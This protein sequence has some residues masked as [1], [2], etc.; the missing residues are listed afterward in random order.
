M[1]EMNLRTSI[2]SSDL[3]LEFE[4]TAAESAR[5][6]SALLSAEQKSVELQ[7]QLHDRDSEVLQVRQIHPE[8]AERFAELESSVTAIM[9]SS[10]QR[11]EQDFE[12]PAILE[13]LQ[14]L[15]Q[16]L[17]HLFR[18]ISSTE[19]RVRV[20]LLKHENTSIITEQ[21][22]AQAL[23]EIDVLRR[24]N[25][26]MERYLNENGGGGEISING[27]AVRSKKFTLREKEFESALQ[28][29]K[30]EVAD[31]DK[32][33]LCMMEQMNQ[34]AASHEAAVLLSTTLLHQ[35]KTLNAEIERDRQRLLQVCIKFTVSEPY[36]N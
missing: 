15:T 4:E 10:Q 21:E 27:Y 24:R 7:H 5:L 1:H 22:L 18:S 28:E 25:A 14:E 33:I 12:I 9:R 8:F 23:A 20:E 19:S 2:A 31:R 13:Q 3:H 17:S 29:L 26:E 11:Q 35:Q 16:G 34:A 32:C 6:K 36:G 30:M